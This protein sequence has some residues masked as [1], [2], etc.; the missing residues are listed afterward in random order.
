LHVEPSLRDTLPGVYL[1]RDAAEAAEALE[2]ML[3]HKA[4]TLS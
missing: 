2:A 1:G 4:A 3:R